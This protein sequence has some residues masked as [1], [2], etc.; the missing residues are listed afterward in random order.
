VV[1]VFP[2]VPHLPIW[3]NDPGQNKYCKRKPIRIQDHTS[4]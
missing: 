1:V 3:Q 2:G 4:P